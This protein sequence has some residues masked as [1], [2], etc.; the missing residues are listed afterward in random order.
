MGRV[1]GE[2]A[3]AFLQLDEQDYPA[4]RRIA[5]L[6]SEIPPDSV[7]STTVDVL[8][9]GISRMSRHGDVS[10]EADNAD[11]ALTE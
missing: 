2:D 4:T 5:P 11:L 7:F 10:L 6:L 1:A 8:V 9:A 3:Q